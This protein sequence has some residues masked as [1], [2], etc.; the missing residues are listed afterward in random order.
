MRS[1]VANIWKKKKNRW[2]QEKKR[3]RKIRCPKPSEMSKK[4]NAMSVAKSTVLSSSS[5]KGLWFAQT[6][7]SYHN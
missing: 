7:V 4:T 1:K 6:A 2:R 5:T 3:L